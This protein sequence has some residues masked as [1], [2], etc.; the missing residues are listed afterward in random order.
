MRAGGRGVSGRIG[1]LAGVLAALWLALLAMSPHS[2]ATAL[3]FAATGAML[4][5][6]LFWMVQR[7][8]RGRGLN[9]PQ[10]SFPRK[11]WGRP[12]APQ[13]ESLPVALLRFSEDGA[14]IAANAAA[15][16]LIGVAGARPMAHEL[17]EDLGRPVAEWLRDVATGRHPG[18]TEVLR[19]RH[20]NDGER[21][22]QVTAQR[23]G[24][25][26]VLA[27]LQ[28]ATAM[29]RL[30]A[31]MVQSQK[32]QAIGQLAG[33]IAH[34]FNNLLTAITGHCDLLMLRHPPDDLDHVDLQQIQQNAYR[35]GA[36]V[37]Q[38]LA[39]S[40][41]QTMVPERID[42]AEA[43]GELTHLLNRLLGGAVRLD[44]DH[45]P[46]PVVLRAD[47]RQFE[48]VIINLAVNARDAM[49][50]GG[51][52]RIKTELVTLDQ[53]ARHDRVEV[54]RG[55]YA[56]I[57]LADSGTGIAPDVLDKI[58]EPFFTTK[59][60][61][62]G[63][64]LGLST[65]Y[66]IVKQSGGYIFVD[67]TPGV[68][69]EFSLWFPATAD[70]VPRPAV[71][72]P[73]PTR[74]T[75]Q[76]AVLLVEDEAPVRAFAARAL[77]LRGLTVIEADSGEQALSVLSQPINIDLFITDV[78]LPGIDGPGWVRQALETR[79]GTPVVFMSGYAAEA[80][81]EAQARIANSVFL[82][83]PFSLADLA[84]TVAG[85]LP[86]KRTAQPDEALSVS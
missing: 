57:R 47:K 21:F 69:T 40:R 35:A 79:P 84:D 77:R 4:A 16:A 11:L 75:A 6:P 82:A 56:V 58:F 2:H 55:S 70:P 60:A 63:T 30:E 66:G 83:K 45:A 32:M 44:L 29:K 59:R 25:A 12:Q 68:G 52:L 17:F 14:L 43:L 80:P 64:G 39:F 28:D 76:G 61:G 81:S 33:G 37:R 67:S 36:L 10:F 65:V 73:R 42:L 50:A 13:F 53:P 48:Q 41:K 86:Q 74:R 1:V 71:T 46:V 34:D 9:W 8:W 85:H 62:E 26:E 51:I 3:V 54:P 5:L 27:V 49:P 18:G 38:L 24:E 22:A 78:K 72:A 7:A 23:L 31:Q 15:R 20:G 19:L